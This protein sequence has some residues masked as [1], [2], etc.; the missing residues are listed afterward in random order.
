[1]VKIYL[2]LFFLISSCSFI[3]GINQNGEITEQDVLGYEDYLEYLKITR[4]GQRVVLNAFGADKNY[5]YYYKEF[6]EIDMKVLVFKN[7][8]LNQQ[9]V[10][11]YSDFLKKNANA[12]KAANAVKALNLKA[13]INKEVLDAYILLEEFLEPKIEK[14]IKKI[15]IGNEVGGAVINVM[16]LS[17]IVN[18]EFR[19]DEIEVV[20]F[21][22]P[23]FL[24]SK[25]TDIN[26][27][28]VNL[29]IDE[30]TKLSVRCCSR[31]S[32]NKTITLKS[33]GKLK[34]TDILLSY[35]AAIKAL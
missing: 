26:S 24:S 25:T 34:Q 21:G 31:F 2:I 13:D 33:S 18:S 7:L 16:A 8:L 15:F 6:K 11:I 19:R 12:Y 20:S 30:N 35:Q 1:M 3:P 4:S 14:R 27:S 17:L 29:D 23:N 32:S 28:F 22:T 10:V 5:K 9:Y